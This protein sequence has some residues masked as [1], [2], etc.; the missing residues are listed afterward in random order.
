MSDRVGDDWSTAAERAPLSVETDL[1]V[2]LDGQPI[3]VTSTGERLFVELPS[4]LAGI[5]ALRSGA[6]VYDPRLG[7]LLRTSDLTVEVRV[8]GATVLVVGAD[9]SPGALSERVGAAP[10]EVRLGGVLAALGREA[11]VDARTGRRWLE[12]ARRRN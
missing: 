2:S 7:G 11:V 8:R 3:Q 4:V 5:R 6:P 9:A 10:A 12:T 1:D